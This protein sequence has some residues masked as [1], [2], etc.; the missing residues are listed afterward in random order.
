MDGS[1]NNAVY[2]N[3]LWEWDPATDV[4]TRKADFPRPGRYGAAAFVIGDRGYIGTG[5]TSVD[6]VNDF[7]EYDQSSDEWTRKADFAGVPR[8]SAIGF[9]AGNKG[10]LGPSQYSNLDG[11]S[12]GLWEWD[13][14][15][16]KWSLFRKCLSQLQSSRGSFRK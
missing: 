5:N 16:D 12:Q 7:W 6:V 9:S 4:W 10:Y 3:D 11:V 15:M 8:V 1:G 13:P 2:R 14:V